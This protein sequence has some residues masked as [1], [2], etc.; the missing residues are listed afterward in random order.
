MDSDYKRG[1]YGPVLRAS[2]GYDADD[3]NNS[4]ETQS[5]PDPVHIQ[6][7]AAAAVA[8]GRPAGIHLH[9]RSRFDEFNKKLSND[10]EDSGGDVEAKVTEL[11]MLNMLGG[12][13]SGMEF[14]QL[15]L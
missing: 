12:S 1:N 8:S 5:R 13:I 3:G 4:L 6:G 15:D 7:Q 10:A 9:G 14:E 2:D 11:L